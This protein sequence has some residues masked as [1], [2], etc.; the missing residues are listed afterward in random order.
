VTGEERI[1]VQRRIRDII[2][3]RDG[4][5]L[6]ITDDQKAELLRVTPASATSR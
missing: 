2:Q 4:A 5:L 3:A 1:D 6:V